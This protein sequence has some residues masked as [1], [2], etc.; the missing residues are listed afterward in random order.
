M[1]DPEEK[2]NITDAPIRQKYAKGGCKSK[3]IPSIQV[4]SSVVGQTMIH[5]LS[6]P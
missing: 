5:L 1:I 6:A 4:S 2:R 3:N